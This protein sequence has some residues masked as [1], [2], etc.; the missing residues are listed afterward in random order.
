MIY[1]N[2]NP[3]PELDPRLRQLPDVNDRTNVLSYSRRVKDN[4]LRMVLISSETAPYAA[5]VPSTRT[6]QPIAPS[7]TTAPEAEAEA[8]ATVTQIPGFDRKKYVLDSQ[9]LVYEAL[10]SEAA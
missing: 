7:E 5:D 4:S 8:M 1:S 6:E 2:H 10:E 9:K 3:S